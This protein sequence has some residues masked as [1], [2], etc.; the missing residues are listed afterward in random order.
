MYSLK[1]CL[2]INNLCK[3]GNFVRFRVWKIAREVIL[4]KKPAKWNLDSEKKYEIYNND[5]SKDKHRYVKVKTSLNKSYV[6]IVKRTYFLSSCKKALFQPITK[7][8]HKQ[9]RKKMFKPWAE[10]RQITPLKKTYISRQI[11]GLKITNKTKDLA[12]F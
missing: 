6:W 11:K 1:K 2:Y 4:E 9:S 3:F 8:V 10:I 7:Q 12:S 5:F